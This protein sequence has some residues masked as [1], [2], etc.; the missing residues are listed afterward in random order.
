M[1]EAERL[2]IASKE[3]ISQQVTLAVKI[4]IK[5]AEQAGSLVPYILIRDHGGIEL[6]YINGD[7]RA[8]IRLWE[9]GVSTWQEFGSEILARENWDLAAWDVGEDARLLA[10][11]L[12]EG[13]VGAA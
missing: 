11:W 8:Q 5:I 13:K 9:A 4:S 6:N 10:E 3:S 7:R 12:R 1:T 2:F